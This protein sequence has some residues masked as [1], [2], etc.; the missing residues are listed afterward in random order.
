M[1]GSS[2]KSGEAFC[3]LTRSGCIAGITLMYVGEAEAGLGP[4]PLQLMRASSLSD[5]ANFF[6]IPFTRCLSQC[7]QTA[8]CGSM[9]VR[10]EA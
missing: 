6:G 8:T 5:S 9:K 2:R 3:L 7:L 1:C 4:G 10:A